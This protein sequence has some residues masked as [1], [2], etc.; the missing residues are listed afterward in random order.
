MIDEYNIAMLALVGIEVKYEDTKDKEALYREMKIFTD[1]CNK[2]ELLDTKTD[3]LCA[4]IL[5]HAMGVFIAATDLD[6]YAKERENN[7]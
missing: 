7:E 1:F 4:T 5:Q 2:Y 3:E 6:K